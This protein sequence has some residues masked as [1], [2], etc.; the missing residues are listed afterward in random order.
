MIRWEWTRVPWRP[1]VRVNHQVWQGMAYRTIKVGPWQW[2][3]TE[4]GWVYCWSCGQWWGPR[5]RHAA[6]MRRECPG[7]GLRRPGPEEAR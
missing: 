4:D 1:L 3:R 2:R 7:E 5:S 6:M